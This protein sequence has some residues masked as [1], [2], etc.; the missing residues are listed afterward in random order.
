VDKGVSLARQLASVNLG[1]GHTPANSP[2]RLRNVFRDLINAGK[3]SRDQAIVAWSLVT[4]NGSLSA[5]AVRIIHRRGF[6]VGSRYKVDR[7]ANV[8]RPFPL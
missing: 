2:E 6:R 1:K 8:R 7:S 5:D 4:G 3:I